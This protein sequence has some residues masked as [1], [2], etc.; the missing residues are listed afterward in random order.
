M[1]YPT[2]TRHSIRSQMG[3]AFLNPIPILRRSIQSRSPSD[4]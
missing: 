4:E 2:P 3:R 1:L